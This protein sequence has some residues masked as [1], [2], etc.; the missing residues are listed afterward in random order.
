MT[1]S[2]SRPGLAVSLAVHSGLLLAALVLFK[3]AE[4][5][6]DAQE[7]LPVEVVSDSKLAQMTK[8]EKTAREVKT[9]PRAEK[10]AEKTEK[11]PHP[12]LA[13]AKKDVPAPPPPL[14]RVADPGKDD[15]PPPPPKRVAAVAPPPPPKPEPVKPEPPKPEPRPPLPPVKP[16]PKA[17]A[18][19]EEDEPEDAEVVKPKPAREKPKEKPAPPP[20]RPKLAEKPVEKPQPEKPK[21]EKIKAEKPKPEKVKPELLKVDEVAKLLEQKKEAEASSEDAKPEKP[22][23]GGKPKSGDETAPKSKFNAASIANL[24][25]REAPQ[26]QASTARERTQVASLGTAEGNAPKLSESMQARIGAYIIDHYRPC[27]AASLSLGVRS[28]QPVVEFHLTRDGA[29]VGAPRLLNP[30]SESVDKARAEQALQAVRKCSP[31]HMPAEF[32]PFYDFWRDTKLR[33]TEEM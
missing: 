15:E 12:A 27:W 6:E 17:A 13:E 30:P 14:K 29:L 11:R 18:E 1:F 33:M 25:S 31:I 19:P 21:P 26:Q 5:F 20:E 23:K 8:G 22:G 9:A 4:I 2:R 28:Y 16:Q 24:L 10:I 32:A 3:D 7:A